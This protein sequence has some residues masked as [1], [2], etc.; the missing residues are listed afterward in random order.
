MQPP[1]PPPPDN[2]KKPYVAPRLVI[3]GDLTEITRASGDLGQPDGGTIPH[4]RKSG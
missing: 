1:A 2:A 3:Y 4:H